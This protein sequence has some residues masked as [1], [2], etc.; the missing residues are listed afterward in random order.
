MYAR[1]LLLRSS[2]LGCIPRRL[3]SSSSGPRVPKQ[4][5]VE[6]PRKPTMFNER[7]Q[8]TYT[9]RLVVKLGSA[10]ITREDEH[11]LALGRLASIVEQVAECQ[12][13]GRECIMVT[14]GAVAF[15][16]QKLAQELLMSLSMRETLSPGGHMRKRSG[17]PLEPRA[18]AAVG[19]SGLMSLY[20][21]MFA[22]YGVK[23]AQVLVTKPDFYNEETRKNLF[24]TLS[25][26]LSLNI[27]PIINT[28]DAVSPPPHVDEEVAGS[29]GRRGISIKDND[30]LAAMLAAE[31]QA[32][33]LIL[34]SDVDGIY[35]LPPW[36]DGAKMLHT[37]SMDLRDT[38]KFGQKSK[39][40]TGGMDAKVNAALWALDRGV[41]VVICN[42][43]QEKAIKNILS[44][45]KIGT[46]FT[47]TTETFAPVEVVAEEARAGSRIL[48]GLQPEER[49]SCI[50]TLA[51]L[52]ES[53][54]REILSANAKDLE[55]AEKS[56]LA[57]ALLSRLS[58][59]P[60]KLK[61]LSSG[62]R[63]IANDSL[64]NVG[65]VLRRT[66]LAEGL[67]LKQITVP[68]GVLL[69]IFESRP[70]SLP[71]V[72]ALAMS[73]ANGLL[74]K[75][76]KEA[77][78]SNRYLMDLVKEALS[79][80]GAANAI[81]LISTREDVGDLLSMGKHIDLV[82]PRGSSD[83][84][85]SIQE[86]SK[87]IPVLGHAEGICHVYVD[88][89]ADLMKAMKII[90]DSKCDYPAACNAMETL[91]IH[92]SHM[93]SSFFTDV[94]NMLQ[95]EG[96]K[97]N[98]GPRLREQLTFGPPAAKSMKTEYGALECAIEVVTDIDDAI[99]HIHKYGS[100]HTDVIVTE[101][102]HS[103]THFA[104]EVDSA[105]VFHNASTRFSDGYRFG[106]G[107]EVGIS[108]ARIHAR[109]P[110]GVDGL[111][112]TKWVLHG[113]GHAAADFAE[114]GD[115]VWLHQ[116]LPINESA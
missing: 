25:E 33:L 44:G 90:R 15:G 45:R 99:N 7:S 102:S 59:T 64:T 82:I 8:L 76:G 66:R 1:L 28:N 79:T 21:A 96:V 43:T 57:K 26:L 63:Q 29:G 78:N 62:L 11:G 113:D 46:F 98:S 5:A 110:V 47:Q 109:G 111:L 14:S 115:K 87:H 34:M 22:Q 9:R 92:E 104:R 80:V 3:A 55:A 97:V 19:Q 4:A 71:Q 89:D 13:G 107:A 70:D 85:R 40:G 51:D 116:S 108:T 91:L 2:K 24:S 65:R 20:D 74:L 83:L 49:A 56:G 75:G 72:A 84:V 54:Q 68:I 48:Q 30:S 27:V 114:G 105:C 36:H 31:I 73:S 23:L 37:F 50:N 112:T 86:Q 12:N 39:V 35:N 69:V 53:R 67:E 77:V 52:L 94:C 6:G 38:I 106:L 18:A 17:T 88:K 58:L 61:S 32:D 95:K 41:S 81:S 10:V 100:G 60:A 42:G 103:A 93:K 16:K 101:N